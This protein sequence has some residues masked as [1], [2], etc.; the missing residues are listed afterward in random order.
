MEK[1]MATTC[2]RSCRTRSQRRP[3]AGGRCG[4]FDGFVVPGGVPASEV[5]HAPFPSDA[6]ASGQD[7]EGKSGQYG[8]GKEASWKKGMEARL[9]TAGALDR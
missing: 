8:E 5:A 6:A 2:A 4:A 9:F 3:G 7:G 1:K